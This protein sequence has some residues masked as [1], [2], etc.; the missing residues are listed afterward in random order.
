M[1]VRDAFRI[2]GFPVPRG[3]KEFIRLS[4]TKF[5]VFK[6]YGEWK[7]HTFAEGGWWPC[8]YYRCVGIPLP[9]SMPAK[10]ARLCLPEVVQKVVPA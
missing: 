9:L 5:K 6:V 2:A 7:G 3:Y 10:D 1:T 4:P 8:S